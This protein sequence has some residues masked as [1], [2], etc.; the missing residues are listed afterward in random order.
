VP[1]QAWHG[2]KYGN[3]GAGDVGQGLHIAQRD[4]DV[5]AIEPNQGRRKDAADGVRKSSTLCVR[6]HPPVITLG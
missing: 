4:A 6:S 1:G 5:F 2:H 3:S